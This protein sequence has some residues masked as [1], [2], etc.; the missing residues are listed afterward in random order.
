MRKATIVLAAALVAGGVIAAD[1]PKDVT[2]RFKTSQFGP[3]LVR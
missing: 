2:G 1:S 3:C